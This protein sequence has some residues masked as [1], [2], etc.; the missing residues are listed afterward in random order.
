M[1]PRGPS[2]C[3]NDGNVVAIWLPRVAVIYVRFGGLNGQYAWRLL[4]LL[5]GQLTRCAVSAENGVANEDGDNL[6]PSEITCATGQEIVVYMN[7]LRDQGGLVLRARWRYLVLFYGFLGDHDAILRRVG[8]RTREDRQVPINENQLGVVHH[9][10][11]GERWLMVLHPI[12]L[13]N[14]R[15]GN[16]ED[17]RIV[18]A[19]TGPK[20]R[21]AQGRGKD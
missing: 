4:V 5:A 14:V 21:C 7:M 12:R 19:A 3:T 13:V 16:D 1:D 18:L 8:H 6:P 2:N 10:S 11:A 9:I 15:L 20:R 17:Q